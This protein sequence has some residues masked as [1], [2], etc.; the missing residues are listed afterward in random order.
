[1]RVFVPK[2]MRCYNCQRFD[3]LHILARG[4]E[5]ALDVEEI[6][7]MASVEQVWNLNVVTVVVLTVWPLVDVKL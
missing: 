1:M 3:I 4:R 7:S 2:P 5:G 6:M